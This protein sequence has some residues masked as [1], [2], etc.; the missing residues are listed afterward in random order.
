MTNCNMNYCNINPQL[1][2]LTLGQRNALLSI[3][4]N[5]KFIT[6][7]SRTTK[8]ARAY[9]NDHKYWCKNIS[10]A[11]VK[12]FS[13]KS[14]KLNIH[15]MY[16][17]GHDNKKENGK[18]NLNRVII[19]GP[20]TQ[21]ESVFYYYYKHH[22]F[23]IRVLTAFKTAVASHSE[24]KYY[25]KTIKLPRDFIWEGVTGKEHTF[26]ITGKDIMSL[27]GYMWPCPTQHP[28][29]I[30]DCW[31]SHKTVCPA[32]PIKT[33]QGARGDVVTSWHLPAP[34]TTVAAIQ[35]AQNMYG[36]P[37]AVGRCNYRHMV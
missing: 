2:K 34:V 16:T 33:I 27:Y 22:D 6:D 13:G 10:L 28:H 21:E 15:P 31:G 7:V 5:S 32:G 25:C 4:Q 37:G 3:M 26:S 9:L 36:L 29:C 20:Q 23:F 11:P 1:C 8:M 12:G 18:S 35:C 24:H 14:V 17:C 30:T 19:Y